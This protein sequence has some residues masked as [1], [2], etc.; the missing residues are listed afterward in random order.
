[1][2]YIQ[3]LGSFLHGRQQQFPQNGLPFS[4][5]SQLSLLSRGGQHPSSWC[6]AQPHAE[7]LMWTSL[8]NSRP[9]VT[10]LL[11]RASCSASK[12][13]GCFGF[14]D[15]C[16]CCCCWAFCKYL[17]IQPLSYRHSDTISQ[18]RDGSKDKEKTWVD[19]VQSLLLSS[20][21]YNMC[22]GE[23]AEEKEGFWVFV[24]HAGLV[25][26]LKANLMICSFTFCSSQDLWKSTWDRQKTRC[27]GTL[28]LSPK[29]INC[30]DH[31]VIMSSC[32]Q[33]S[34]TAEYA[35]HIIISPELPETWSRFKTR[36]V[37]RCEE[38]R[39]LFY[40]LPPNFSIILKL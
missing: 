19:L 16:C 11:K 38:P 39:L 14:H 8:A 7:G 23:K 6:S 40:P 12:V 21:V 35:E 34:P 27:K 28:N 36:R 1:M 3:S 26:L 5:E 24:V 13:L 25:A 30:Y 4:A 18:K 32:L 20:F 37:P 2:F 9:S 10:L 29:T 15:H 31:S 22:K 17:L 33:T